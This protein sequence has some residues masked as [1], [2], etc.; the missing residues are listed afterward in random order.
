MTGPMASYY[1]RQLPPPLNALFSRGFSEASLAQKG[2]LTSNLSL[3][4][5]CG[6]PGSGPNFP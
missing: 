4:G 1:L 2:A 3:W 5:H 6:P